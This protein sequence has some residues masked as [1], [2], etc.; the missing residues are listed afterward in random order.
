MKQIF[1]KIGMVTI[2]SVSA[3]C[4]Q[5]QN[6]D[7]PGH[8]EFAWSGGN[9]L[10]VSGAMTVRVRKDGPARVVVTGPDDLVRRVILDRGHLGLENN[11]SWW[12]GNSW[13]R[14]ERLEV[15]ISGVSLNDV[16]VSGSSNV[17]LAG[18]V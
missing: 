6:V 14:N 13:P 18:S 8:R 11:W 7:R 17:T 5:A 3:A 1:A 2:L 10:S 9:A 4:A 12:G 16:S 15:E